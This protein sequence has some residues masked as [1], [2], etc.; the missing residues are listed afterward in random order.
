[1]PIVGI[2]ISKE[3]HKAYLALSKADRKKLSRKAYD[4]L[5]AGLSVPQDAQALIDEAKEGEQD[6]DTQ[7]DMP[8]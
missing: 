3:Q 5:Q 4:A 2:Y 8:K 6:A 1:M 7:P